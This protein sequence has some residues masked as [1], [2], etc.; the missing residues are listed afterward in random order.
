M[1][2]DVSRLT[3]ANWKWPF[4][5]FQLSQHQ[6]GKSQ[7]EGLLSAYDIDCRHSV[8]TMDQTLFCM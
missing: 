8:T 1:M 7:C 4:S 3:L 2:Y 6:L 5:V